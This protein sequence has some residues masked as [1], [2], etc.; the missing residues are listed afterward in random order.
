ME[1]DDSS[2][3]SDVVLNTMPARGETSGNIRVTR[4]RG[5]LV[6]EIT[7]LSSFC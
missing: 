2:A 3:R 1:I 6:V 7:M 5:G 4:A